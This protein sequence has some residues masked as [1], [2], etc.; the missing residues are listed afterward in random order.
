MRK[1]HQEWEALPRERKLKIIEEAVAVEDEYQ[2]CTA[3]TM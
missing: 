3:S 1:Y 2:V